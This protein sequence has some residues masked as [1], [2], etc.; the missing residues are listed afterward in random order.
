MNN[1]SGNIERRKYIL[2]QMEIKD[3]ILVADLVDKF[4]V[5]EVTIRKDLENLER[6]N[7]LIKVRGGAIRIPRS[8]S[9]QDLDVDIKRHK[10]FNQ[11]QKIG[12]AAAKLVRDSE[13][14]ILDSGSTTYEVATNL[15]KFENL[16]ILTNAINIAALLNSYK[17][18]KILVPG[19]V[20]RTE[21]YSIGGQM[22]E[23]FFSNF[24][25]DKLFLGVDSFIIKQGLFTPNIEEA[26]INRIM[27]SIAKEV[28]AVVDSSKFEKPGFALIAPTTAIHTI[29][30]DS[31]IRNETKEELKKL[32]IK[33]IIAK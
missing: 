6:K 1:P 14:L 17:K 29:I 21:S 15:G 25:C 33:I 8:H 32:G 26:S 24:Y 12:R 27:I 9:I 18:F 22:A 3:S 10:F 2:H 11:K 30:T 20:I 4:E 23:S 7:L 13:T 5:S 19:G 31:G 28:I 16:T